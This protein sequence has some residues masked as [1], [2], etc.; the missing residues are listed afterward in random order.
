MWEQYKNKNGSAVSEK[1]KKFG[2]RV[3][4]SVTSGDYDTLN[5]IA[6]RDD[7]SVSWV[8]RRAIDEYLRRHR[9]PQRKPGRAASA[10]QCSVSERA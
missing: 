4:V 5:A 9:D 2:P 7:V 8:V 10:R 6:G 3:T 1:L